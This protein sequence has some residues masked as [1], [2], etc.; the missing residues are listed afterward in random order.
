MS[1]AIEGLEKLLID[2]DVLEGPLQTHMEEFSEL[3][4]TLH[5]LNHDV[6]W[7]SAISKLVL[8]ME[9]E[10][11]LAYLTKNTA[12]W[13]LVL[14]ELKRPNEELFIDTPHADFHSDTRKAIAQVQN[15]KDFAERH[16]DDVRERLRPLMHMGG[17]WDTNPI[18]FEYVLIIG[19]NQQGRLSEP[20]ANLVERLHS[21]NR[22]T[23]LTWDSIVRMAKY[24]AGKLSRLNILT[25]DEGRFKIKRA[26]AHTNLFAEFHP[27]DIHLDKKEEKWF[28]ENDYDIDAWRSGDLLKLN[29]KY[30]PHRVEAAINSVME[31]AARKKE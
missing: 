25:H 18:E 15:W 26:Q 16:P 3:I 21:E 28:R 31:R 2:R 20:K 23:L 1:E 5:I 11:D 12:M 14:I 13:R 8:K 6:Q 17:H 29:C 30:P 4:P 22:I 9:M 24:K 7:N 19:S 10:V 27:D